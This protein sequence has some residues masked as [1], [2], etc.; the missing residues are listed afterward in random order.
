MEA[1]RAA[2]HGDIALISLLMGA[3]CKGLQVQNTDGKWIDA[4]A[5]KDELMINIGDV[6]FRISN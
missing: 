5:N 4:I 6:V 1:V 2:A 3:H